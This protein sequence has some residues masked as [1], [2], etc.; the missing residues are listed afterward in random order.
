MEFIHLLASTQHLKRLYSTYSKTYLSRLPPLS[1]LA[2]K[3]VSTSRHCKEKLC[4]EVAL[5][6]SVTSQGQIRALRE[7]GYSSQ[8]SLACVTHSCWP[9][10]SSSLCARVRGSEPPTGPSHLTGHA[11]SVK[12]KNAAAEVGDSSPSTGFADPKK[13]NGRTECASREKSVFTQTFLATKLR[14]P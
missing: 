5:C 8:L 4:P 13:S 7:E 14:K 11:V 10:S 3:F 2:N 6:H 1:V 12:R 9:L